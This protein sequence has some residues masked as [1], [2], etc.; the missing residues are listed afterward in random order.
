MEEPQW[1][2]KSSDLNCSEHFGDKLEREMNHRLSHSTSVP[3]LTNHIQISTP[4][5]QSLL[6]SL[7]RKV[8]VKKKNV[9]LNLYGDVVQ[10]DGVHKPL[11]IKCR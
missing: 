10:V 3:D 7:L 4:T 6:E 5:L 11:P 8:E 1:P 2:A 9:G